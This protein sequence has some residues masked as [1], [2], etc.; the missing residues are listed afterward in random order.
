MSLCVSSMYLTASEG[1]PRRGKRHCGVKWAPSVVSR[2]DKALCNIDCPGIQWHNRCAQSESGG[3]A[4][5]AWRR[6][7]FFVFLDI[8][9]VIC[10]ALQVQVTQHNE[11]M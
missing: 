3:F 10:H 6:R 1:R 8:P 4:H 7:T 5:R 2:R 11:N 9:E